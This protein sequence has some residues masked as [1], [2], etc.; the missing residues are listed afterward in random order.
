L[1][2]KRRNEL[3]RDAAIPVQVGNLTI[4]V[5]LTPRQAD[6]VIRKADRAVYSL[7]ATG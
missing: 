3:M 5:R 7:D 4:D 1:R 6:A 2:A